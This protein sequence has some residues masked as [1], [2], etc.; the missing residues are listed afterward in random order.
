MTSP[1]DLI[2]SRLDRV[3]AKTNGKGYIAACPTAAHRNGDRHPSLSVDEGENGGV[4]LHCFSQQCAA[5]E[6]VAA[7]GLNLADLYPPR[8]DSHQPTRPNVPAIPLRDLFAIV[9]PAL[10]AMN[11]AFN[12]VAQGKPIAPEAA[13]FYLQ[14]AQRLQDALHRANAYKPN[15]RPQQ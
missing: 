8:P 13:A 5:A 10:T 3:K 2:L 1:I 15:W 9:Y 14:Q 11:M 12:T 6:I 7:L 4:L